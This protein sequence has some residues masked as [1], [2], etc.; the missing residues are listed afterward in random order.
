MN[1][2]NLGV[3]LSELCDY[4][5]DQSGIICRIY[6]G[7]SKFAKY[8]VTDYKLEFLSKDRNYMTYFIDNIRLYKRDIIGKPSD[9]SYLNELLNSNNL[10]ELCSK[11][12]K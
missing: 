6:N 7:Y 2:F 4:S 5:F 8:N 9:Q 3:K 12:E 1:N 11:F 10:L